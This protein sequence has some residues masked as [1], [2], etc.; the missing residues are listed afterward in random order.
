MGPDSAVLDRYIT[1]DT[2]VVLDLDNTVFC[3]STLIGGAEWFHHLV[4]RGWRMALQPAAMTLSYVHFSPMQRYVTVEPCEAGLA[5]R[6]KN[7]QQT[8]HSVIA[9]T[10]RQPKILP[11][12]IEHLHSIDVDFSV[13]PWVNNDIRFDATYPASFH[14]GVIFAHDCN[15]KGEIFKQFLEQIADSSFA[16]SVFVDDRQGNISSMQTACQQKNIEFVGLRYS[17]QD[18]K[19]AALILR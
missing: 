11:P 3:S 14:E 1:A 2:L 7:W 5:H 8:A 9:L 15:P 13:H 16:E 17:G 6:I 12:T 19:A 4:H 18:D 10:A